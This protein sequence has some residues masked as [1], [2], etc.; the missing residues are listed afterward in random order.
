MAHYRRCLHLSLSSAKAIRTSIQHAHQ[1]L[2][3]WT[4]V[5]GRIHAMTTPKPSSC[6]PLC[7]NLTSLSLD[8]AAMLCVIDTSQV[9]QHLVLVLNSSTLRGRYCVCISAAIADSSF[10]RFIPNTPMMSQLIRPCWN[11]PKLRV[12]V[13]RSKIAY[14]HCLGVL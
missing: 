1:A 8:V 14:T 9:F 3:C 11:G 6:K 7:N 10:I 2:V 13:V 12:L 4:E 5:V